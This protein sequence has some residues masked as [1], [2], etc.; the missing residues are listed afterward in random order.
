MSTHRIIQVVAVGITLLA[1]VAAALFV[2]PPVRQERRRLNLGA[3]H[4][5]N[6][7]VK[8]DVA[9]ASSM[10]GPLKGFMVNALWYRV[11]QLK[12]QGK[13]AEINELS[14][15]ITTLQP[16]F[17][18]VW[19]FHAW[20]MAYNVSVQ[21]FTPEE[22]WDWVNKGV[23]LLREEGIPANPTAVKLYRELS[24]IF[25]HKFGQYS[26]DAHW[27]YKVELCREWQ[28]LLGVPSEGRDT[29]GAKAEFRKIVDAPATLG[30]LIAG[31]PLVRTLLD[32]Q[33][34]P[35]EYQIESGVGDGP[36]KERARLLRA[37]GKVLVY[38]YTARL[39]ELPLELRPLPVYD[40]KLLPML[41]NEAYRPALAALL[42]HLRRVVLIE[43]YHMDPAIMLAIMDDYGPVDYRTSAAHSLYW[44]HLGISMME[45]WFNNQNFDRVNTLRQR[46]HSLQDM[47]DSGRLLFFPEV[48]R[49]DTMPDV[50]FI[51]AYEKALEQAEATLD[52]AE[53]GDNKPYEAGHENF[54]LKA[55]VLHYQSGDM[56]AARAYRDKAMKA[57]G[58]REHNVRTGRYL[59]PM[60]D[61]FTIELSSLIDNNESL[62][63]FLYAMTQRAMTAIAINDRKTATQILTLANDVYQRYMTTINPTPITE[64]DRMALAPGSLFTNNFIEIMR[65][66]SLLEFRARLWRHAPLETR[67]A[68]WDAVSARLRADARQ[69]KLNPDRVFPEPEGMAAYRA[70]NPRPIAP[71]TGQG[72]GPLR[73]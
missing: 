38:N 45:D 30:Q 32:E 11:E 55:F 62:R 2:V 39:E 15:M 23:R 28:E 16:R 54:L 43:T 14:R 56:E 1:L 48:G 27:Y 36:K 8:P 63:A 24:W 47:T 68:A 19:R 12:Q 58:T 59:L 61:H 31:Q 71:T 51:P 66:P 69:A 17:P 46:I 67:Q 3:S 53:G 44:S 18:E 37:I 42:S 33:I 70:A 25:F 72:T 4:T 9:F 57:Y 29:E 22:R 13:F 7:S 64:Q 20:N 34:I 49:V 40:E 35:A 65:Q 21:T 50:R 41:T 5:A 60:K 6:E 10:L 73:P 26:D 52:K